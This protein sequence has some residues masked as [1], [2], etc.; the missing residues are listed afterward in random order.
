MRH[1]FVFTGEFGR[2]PD[3]NRRGGVAANGRGHNAD[4]MV[5]L[6]TGGGTP[7]G[8]IVGATDHVG[9]RAVEVVHPMR[10]LHVTL[11]RLLAWMITS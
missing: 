11:L 1:F 9:S 7:S 6:L 3:N 8:K 2:T 5:V 10:D 4:A